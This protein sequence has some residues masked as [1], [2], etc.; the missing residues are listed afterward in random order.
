VPK[1][2]IL[3]EATKLKDAKFL[4]IGLNIQ[5]ITTTLRMAKPTNLKNITITVTS[6]V[7]LVDPVGEAIRRDWQ[8]LDHLLDQLWTSLSICPKI[9]YEEGW[10]VENFGELVLTL[11]PKLASK[12]FVN[13]ATTASEC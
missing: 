1:P 8:D 12:G 7:S 4:C 13:R 11:L 2:L 10:V 3:S 9:W 5:W 6:G